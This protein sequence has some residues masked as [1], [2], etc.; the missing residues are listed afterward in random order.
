MTKP[1]T[2]VINGREYDAKTGMPVTS[3]SQPADQL[4][5]SSAMH[6]EIHHAK[7]IHRHT[8]RSQTLSR[9]YVKPSKNLSATAQT[10][11]KNTQQAPH[12]SVARF[13]A[14]P[15]VAKSPTSSQQKAALLN[16]KLPNRAITPLQTPVKV[17]V[18]QPAKK[19]LTEVN[20]PV[21]H[22]A[23]TRA[24]AVQQRR[25]QPKET[26][27]A[28]VIKQ[29]VLNETINAAPTHHAKQFKKER[30]TRS[31]ILG[32]VSGFAALLLFA[33]YL[34]YLNVPNLSVRV[35]AAQA[36]IDASYPGYH[37]DGYRL[38]GPVAFRDG[39]VRMTFAANTGESNFILN[40]SRSNWDSSALLENYVKDKFGKNYSTTQ[41]KGLTIYNH[42]GNAAWVSG[43]ILYTIDGNAPLSPD[44]IRKIAT[45]V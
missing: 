24:H 5:K 33:G 14:T 30:S 43:G 28:S 12:P 34:T 9:K 22:P 4:K 44:Q 21:Q 7:S 32:L 31:R 10:T 6:G 1:Q 42:E 40:Q 36:G 17:H 37:P 2:I 35:A 8:Q 15:R 13:H 39:H 19:K 38:N 18:A 3:S 16:G 26:P 20:S 27:Q 41:D 11:E 23:V 29:A 45:S 25:K